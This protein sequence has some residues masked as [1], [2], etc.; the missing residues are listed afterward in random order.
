MKNILI[1][2]GAGYLGTELTKYLLS[3]HNVTI[4]DK[5]YFPWIK[6]NAYKVNNY[7]RLKFLEKN[8]N[9]INL[10]DFKD[11]DIVCD[12]NG[13][14][15]DP[16]SE[17]DPKYTW[18]T[19]FKGRLKFAKIAKKAGVKRY[20][21]NSTCS[22]YGFNEKIVYEN[23][24]KNPLSSYAKANLKAE[25]HIYKIKNK[26]FK[27]NVLRNSTLFGFSSTLRL[28]LVINI[29]VFN[30]LKNKKINVDGNGD[31]FRPFISVTD[32]CKIYKKIINNEEIPSFIT[33]IVA[34]NS[35][36]RKLA[37][38]ICSILKKNKQLINFNNTLKD[39]RS[40]IVESNNFNK[41]FNNFKYCTLKSQ[42]LALKKN[43]IKERV[44]VDENTIRL[45]F[46]KKK[47]KN[48]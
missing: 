5:F 19:N 16:A 32:V 27:V 13:I 8:I 30:L 9:E 45:K 33:N 21:F 10:N 4:Y 24:I 20:I 31:Q 25:N 48:V 11:I 22:I 18:N 36:I 47:L 7:K 40:Y 23:S 37:L 44:K 1:S 43:I 14:P 38:K 34:F 42:V 28:D 6:K 26:N 2:G 3:S 29:F 35:D 46:Y 12:L 15:N 39:H 17:I 41:Y